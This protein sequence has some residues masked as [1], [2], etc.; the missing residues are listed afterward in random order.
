VKI[1]GLQSESDDSDSFVLKSSIATDAK[2]VSIEQ[3]NSHLIALLANGVVAIFSK[4]EDDIVNYIKAFEIQIHTERGYRLKVCPWNY[5]SSNGDFDFEIISCG[6]KPEVVHTGFKF[7]VNWNYQ[8][9]G[10]SNT[11]LIHA[12]GVMIGNISNRFIIPA[13][14]KLSQQQS[15][16]QSLA[17]YCLNIPVKVL[18]RS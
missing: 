2:I 13:R 16:S 7:D 14:S 3:F 4:D 1:F 18:M 8:I 12:F 9:L 5:S 11:I 10:V 17:C 6:D 15:A